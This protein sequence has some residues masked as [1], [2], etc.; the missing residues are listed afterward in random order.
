MRI[1]IQ[2]VTHAEVTV[3]GEQVSAIGNGL[4]VLVGVEQGDTEAD[5]EWLAAKTVGLRIFADE[6]GVILRGC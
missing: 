2:R 5:V 1:V 4:M 6:N 3:D